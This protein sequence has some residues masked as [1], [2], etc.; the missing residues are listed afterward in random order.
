MLFEEI[1]TLFF[2]ILQNWDFKIFCLCP[3]CLMAKIPVFYWF[4]AALATFGSLFT[5]SAIFT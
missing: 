2:K 5:Y 3:F 1:K 4:A